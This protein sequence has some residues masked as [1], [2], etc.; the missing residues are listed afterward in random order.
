[1]K[2]LELHSVLIHINPVKHITFSP[3]TSHLC[4]ST[5]SPRVNVWTPYSAAI[6]ELAPDGTIATTSRM[7][8][9]EVKWNPKG[10]QMILKDQMNAIIAFPTTDFKAL[11]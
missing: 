4:I 11:V 5:T 3:T 9:T 8:I 10:N 6:Y 1:M 2:N 7:N